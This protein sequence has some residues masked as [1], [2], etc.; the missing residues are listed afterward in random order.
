VDLT[1]QHQPISDELTA[2]VRQVIADGAFVLGPAVERFE[3]AYASWAGVRHVVGVA[4]GTDAIELLLRALGIGP[5]DEV[6]VP[7]LT[8]VATAAAVSRTGARPRLVDVEP[9]SLL[10]DA[11]LVSAARTPRTRAIIPVDLYGQMAAFEAFEVMT[12]LLVLEDGAQSQGA[13][14]FGLGPGSWGRGASTSFYPGKN[15]G[16]LG[17]AGA[18]LVNDDDLAMRLRAL[19]NHGG[20]RRYQHDL[21]GVNS[22]LDAVQAAALEVKLRYLD[23]WNEQRREAAARYSRMLTEL[24]GVV[25]VA[26]LADNVHVWHL[27]VV[28]V[29]ER[30]R[31]LARL[32]SAGIGAAIHYPQPIHRLGAFERLG[33]ALGDFPVAERAAGEILSLPLFPGITHSEQERVVEA[34]HQ[35]LSR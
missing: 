23:A 13:R 28:R 2:A 26:A 15:L 1:R 11:G 30:D 10:I 27:Y 31:V 33:Y 18:I 8:F 22:R 21:L 4:N 16:A 6:I 25:P 9:E 7:A 19:R 5:G 14:R 17:D 3:R 32:N 20:E 24:K 12:D 34:L 29:P 35:A